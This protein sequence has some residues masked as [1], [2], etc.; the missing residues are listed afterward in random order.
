[1][2]TTAH[3]VVMRKLAREGRFNT[4]RTKRLTGKQ[5]DG[6]LCD[7]RRCSVAG[8]KAR[9]AGKMDKHAM[10]SYSNRISFLPTR[11]EPENT[12]RGHAARRMKSVWG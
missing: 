4:G 5:M 3:R 2:E 11:T 1:M 10:P 12:C 7:H 9:A 6:S 8:E